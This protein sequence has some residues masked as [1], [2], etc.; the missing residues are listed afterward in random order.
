MSEHKGKGYVGYSKSVNATLAEEEGRYPATAASKILKLDIET[1]RHF[2]ETENQEYHHTGKDYNETKYYDVAEIRDQIN[3]EIKEFDKAVKKKKG[4]LLE[5]REVVYKGCEVEWR[6]PV[7]TAYGKR[8]YRDRKESGCVVKYNGLKTYIITT[9]SGERV[10]KIEGSKGF[11]FKTKDELKQE[12]LEI[13]QRKASRRLMVSTF[14]KE[15]KEMLSDNSKKLVVLD[16]NNFYRQYG[17]IIA[18]DVEEQFEPKKLTKKAFKEALKESGLD[19]AKRTVSECMEKGYSRLGLSQ[20]VIH[21]DNP[22]KVLDHLKSYKINEY[23]DLYINA[24][25]DF[26]ETFIEVDKL[27][28][29]VSDRTDDLAIEFKDKYQEASIQSFLNDSNSRKKPD[30]KIETPSNRSSRKFC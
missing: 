6:Q 22:T 14:N 15:L 19:Y 3:D 2:F 29:L 12:A 11:S 16:Y 30:E 8:S 17:E 27:N 1:L 26:V 9:P 24:G 25:S 23:L 13:K 10:E 20:L 21:S 4:K 5:E 28:E 18:L 7:K